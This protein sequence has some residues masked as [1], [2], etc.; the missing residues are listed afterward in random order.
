MHLYR[1]KQGAEKAGQGDAPSPVETRAMYTFIYWEGGG[2][3]G[4]RGVAQILRD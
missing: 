3:G 4:A 2:A 1:K